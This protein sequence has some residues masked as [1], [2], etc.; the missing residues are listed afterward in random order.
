MNILLVTYKSEEK[1]KDA[2]PH[3]RQT[4]WVDIIQTNPIELEKH[5]GNAR[6]VFYRVKNFYPML[7]HDSI[8]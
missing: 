4:L 2:N 3:S 1:T 8:I 5:C 6:Y 7:K